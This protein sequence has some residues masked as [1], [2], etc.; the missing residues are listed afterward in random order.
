MNGK[1]T[2]LKN[3]THRIQIIVINTLPVSCAKIV[4]KKAYYIFKLLM[5]LNNLKKQLF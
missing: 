4:T 3:L 1:I 2:E 5:F